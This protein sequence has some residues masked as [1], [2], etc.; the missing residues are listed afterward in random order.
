MRNNSILVGHWPALI[1]TLRILL[2][3]GGS[4]NNPPYHKS[5]KNSELCLSTEGT[6]EFP[7]KIKPHTYA[8][9]L[10]SKTLR[11]LRILR[12]QGGT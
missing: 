6:E 11:T 7:C 9:G 3:Y 10:Y 4:P 2:K 1:Q 12:T 5:R 8:R